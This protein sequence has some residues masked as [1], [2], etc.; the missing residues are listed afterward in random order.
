M[1]SLSERLYF[2]CEGFLSLL[3]VFNCVPFRYH[4]MFSLI[5][6]KINVRMCQSAIQWIVFCEMFLIFT[7]LN[8]DL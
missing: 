5:S 4:H 2:L 8:R 6:D 7:Q 1:Y 3:N